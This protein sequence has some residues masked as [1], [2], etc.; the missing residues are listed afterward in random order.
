MAAIDG[1]MDR[2]GDLARGPNRDRGVDDGQLRCPRG[3]VSLDPFNELGSV[4][5]GNMECVNGACIGRRAVEVVSFRA[6]EL[7]EGLSHL[8]QANDEIR[9][10]CQGG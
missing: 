6:E 3:L 2:L 4:G 7:A 5:K 10:G 1:R 9:H 8:A